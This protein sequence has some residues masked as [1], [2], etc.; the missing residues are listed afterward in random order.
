[1]ETRK[2]VT[3][4]GSSTADSTRLK[5]RGRDTLNDI[6]GHV[7]FAEAFYLIATGRTA[8]DTTR[9]VMDAALIILMDHGITPTAIVARLV[10]DSLPTQP[11]VAVAAGLTMIGDK[12]VGSM[13]SVGEYLLK[14]IDQPDP[15]AWVKQ[16]VADAQKSKIRLAGFGHPYYRPTDPRSDRLFAIAR[17]AGVKGRFID[18]IEAIGRELSVVRPVTLNVTAALGAVLC[19][20]GLPP[21]AMRG[22]AVVGRAAGLIAHVQEERA[23]PTAAAFMDFSSTIEYRED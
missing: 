13:S 9:K 17:E 8:D 4:I 12:F 18:L 11:Q 1:M 16:F 5:M 10:A 22:V 19:E 3:R 15:A 23:E 6:M 14:G 2:P 21:T 7:S 20:I